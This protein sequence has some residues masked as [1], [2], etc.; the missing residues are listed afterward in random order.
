[1][2]S[3]G[4]RGLI[5]KGLALALAGLAVVACASADKTALRQASMESSKSL[6][7]GDYGK[8][9]DLYRKLYEKDR[10]NGRI[11]S[12]CAAMIEHVKAAG[13]A[14]RSKGSWA[15]AQNAYRVLTVNWDWFSSLAP[16]LTFKRADLDAGLK[17]CRLGLCERQFR[18]EI[19]AG[20]CVKAIAIYQSALKD[21]H[22][23]KAVKARYAKGIAEIWE[24]GA[25]ALAAKD[26]ALA[27]K[28]DGLLLKNLESFEGIVGTAAGGRSSREALTEALRVCSTELTNAGLAEYRKGN[29]E[30]AIAFWDDLLAFD[31]GNAEIKKAIETARVQ[32]GKLKSS[33]KGSRVGSPGKGKGRQVLGSDV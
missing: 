4:G 7:A 24:M 26:Y 5:V 10:T 29:L 27:G 15:A 22:E 11:V 33:S 17:D 28:I 14:A 9:I 2:N 19:D 13:D 21:C 32:L 16:R 31:P 25:Q 18:Q 1:M 8:A 23:D 20:N 30:N 6:A 12:S 3:T